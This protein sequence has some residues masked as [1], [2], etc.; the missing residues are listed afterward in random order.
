MRRG[1]RTVSS[2]QGH[3]VGFVRIGPPYVGSLVLR[4]PFAL[5]PGSGGRRALV[6]FASALPCVIAAPL[7]VV[8]LGTQRRADGSS[9]NRIWMMLLVVLNPIFVMAIYGGHPEEILGAVL[10]VAGVVL[11]VRGRSRMAASCSVLP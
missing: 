5:I 4:A 3:V 7:F 1:R 10:C 9:P 11:A 2:T 8:W 6:Y